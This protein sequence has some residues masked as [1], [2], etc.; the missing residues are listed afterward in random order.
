MHHGDKISDLMK[1]IIFIGLDRSPLT[2]LIARIVG[3]E[4]NQC[5]PSGSRS[6]DLGDWCHVTSGSC[7]S[8]S[9]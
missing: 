3:Y 4:C 1:A 5:L 7:S 6:L 9:I 2:N 8:G